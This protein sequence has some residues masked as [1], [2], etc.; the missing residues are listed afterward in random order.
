MIKL[1]E[2][3]LKIKLNTVND[4]KNF[5]Q[6]CEGYRKCSIDVKQGRWIIDGKSMM[7]IFSLNLTEPLKV[8][9]DYENDNV[10]LNFYKDIK[11]WAI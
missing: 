7:G 2:K 1:G 9:I 6:I 11:K 3:K 10:K 5:V 8:I 4:V